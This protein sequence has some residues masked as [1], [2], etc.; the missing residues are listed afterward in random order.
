MTRKL[1]PQQCSSYTTDSGI[2]IPIYFN[3]NDNNFIAT[4]NGEELMRE[5]CNDLY[6]LVAQ[7]AQEVWDWVPIIHVKQ[8]EASHSSD[9]TPIVGV[10]AD[11]FY[12]A[13]PGSCWK[14]CSW[15]TPEVA[16]KEKWARS[17]YP[18]HGVSQDT[19]S[20]PSHHGKDHY[21]EYSEPLW[22]GLMN[23]IK[24]IGVARGK[25][26]TL[27]GTD[28]TYRKIENVWQNVL[29]APEGEK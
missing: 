21:L 11:R 13:R 8:Y 3:R 28:E 24:Q 10:S 26:S 5:K 15:E 25:L 14:V 23:L 1:K 19:F 20:V 6:L 2:E 22:Q 16:A 7:K 18:P 27:L 29:A 4:V 12:L 9:Q 17:F